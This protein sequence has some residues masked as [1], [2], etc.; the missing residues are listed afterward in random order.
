MLLTVPTL[1]YFRD[2]D[3]I[4]I[5]HQISSTLMATFGNADPECRAALALTALKAGQTVSL[6][7]GSTGGPLPKE[8]CQIVVLLCGTHNASASL[9]HLERSVVFFV[10]HEST[11]AYLPPIYGK[12]S[13]TFVSVRVRERAARC[14]LSTPEVTGAF[15][16]ACQAKMLV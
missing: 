4:E 5:T 9:P 11:N 15:A 6:L 13:V 16:S 14:G 7:A 2:A 1:G 8:R 10:L 12:P 3:F